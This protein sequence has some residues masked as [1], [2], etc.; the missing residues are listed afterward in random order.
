VTWEKS[1]R[2]G[3]K[4]L[5]INSTIIFHQGKIGINMIAFIKKDLPASWDSSFYDM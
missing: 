3:K 4:I 5:I 1:I 2:K